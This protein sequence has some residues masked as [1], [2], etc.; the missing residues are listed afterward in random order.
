MLLEGAACQD[1]CSRGVDGDH[2]LAAQ[3]L[4]LDTHAVGVDQAEGRELPCRMKVMGS[5]LMGHNLKP[6]IVRPEEVKSLIVKL[7]RHRIMNG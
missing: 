3:S 4:V 1:G 5:W 2:D 7:E 6:L